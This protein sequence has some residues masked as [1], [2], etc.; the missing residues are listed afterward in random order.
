MSA[1]VG[2]GLALDVLD[3]PTRATLIL[4][5]DMAPTFDELSTRGVAAG[6]TDLE[7]GT[8]GWKV[9]GAV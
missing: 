5:V 9:A 2:R 7:D 6:V 8:V 3:T 4:L 1:L